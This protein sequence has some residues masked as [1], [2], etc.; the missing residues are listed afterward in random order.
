MSKEALKHLED[1]FRSNLGKDKEELTITEL[2]K[3]V[4]SKNVSNQNLMIIVFISESSCSDFLCG[5]GLP[6]I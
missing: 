4:P 3:I 1:V 2:K 5:E 6:H